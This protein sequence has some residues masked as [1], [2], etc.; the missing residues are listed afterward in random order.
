MDRG[1]RDM[2]RMKRIWAAW[3]AV[4]M[5]V[6]L[7]APAA[8]AATATD[9]SE[10]PHR[11]ELRSETAATC[12]K[13]GEKVYYCMICGS[14]RTETVKRLPHDYGSW[15]TVREATCAR[16]GERTRKCK[17][18][19]HEDTRSIDRLPHQWGEWTVLSEPTDH[20]S[21]QRTRTCSVCG[22]TQEEAIDPEGTL[23][24]GD[25]GEAVKAL[26]DLLV[27]YG[28]LGRGGAD[29]S[30]GRGT[31]GAVKQV[32]AAEGLEADGVAWPQ[33]QAVLGHRFGEWEVVSELS[34]F[35]MGLRQRVCARCGYVEREE[36]WPSPM[37]RRGDR[38]DGVRALQNALSDA[39]YS[40]G[41]ADGDFGRRTESAV[42][43]FEAA[44][45]VQADGI[46][47]PG[48][49]RLLGLRN[50]G[51][52][53]EETEEETPDF[54]MI[55]TPFTDQKVFHVGEEIEFRPV[56]YNNA[57]RE[58][59]DAV[60]R[61]YDGRGE[62]RQQ[63]DEGTLPA[64]DFD[65]L[66]DPYTFVEADIGTVTFKWEADAVDADGNK[67]TA[68]PQ[69]LTYTV[70]PAEG[71]QTPSQ[72]EHGASAP[73]LL[74]DPTA[75]RAE[76]LSVVK[77]VKGDEDQV[78]SQGDIVTFEI[79]VANLTAD[80]M[81]DARVY[82]YV[83]GAEKGLPVA[84]GLTIKRYDTA[85]LNFD[86]IVTA[87]DAA[88]GYV[89]DYAVAE[90]GGS[91]ARSN[92]V[93]ILVQPGTPDPED[94]PVT[95]TKAIANL[96]ERGYFLVGET[97]DFTLTLRNDGDGDITDIVIRDPLCTAEDNVVDTFDALAPGGEQTA[98]LTYEVTALDLLHP[99]INIGFA[100]FDDPQGFTCTVI[101][102]EVEVPTGTEP[103]RD[104]DPIGV[105]TGAEVHKAVA[106]ASHPGNGWYYT[107]GED[108]VYEITVLNCGE[109]VLDEVTVYDTLAGGSGEI[110]AIE[111]FM[112]GDSRTYLFTHTVSKSDVK[113]GKVINQ[114]WI[115]WEIEGVPY[116]A[117]SERV[118]SPTGG[119]RA[120]EPAATCCVP[121]LTGAGLNQRTYTLDYCGEHRAVAYALDRAVEAAQTDDERLAAWNAAA[122]RW[123]EALNAEYD[124]LLADATED[125][126]TLVVGEKAL[127]FAQ[128]ACLKDALALTRPELTVAERMANQLMR[129]T[130]E[131]CY[132]RHTAPE[133]RTDSLYNP[134]EALP[135]AEAPALCGVHTE[136]TAGGIAWTETLCATHSPAEAAALNLLEEAAT[137]EDRAEAWRSVAQ[138]WLTALNSA[139]NARWQAAAEQGREIIA[140]ERVAF[141]KWLAAQEDLLNLLYPGRPVTTGERVARL[142]RERVLELERE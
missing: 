133:N 106:A 94:D 112:P 53:E 108:I 139:A 22:A 140:A 71:E 87:E 86:Y 72:E 30:F 5:L 81:T 9:P 25:R 134:H 62:L 132:A 29:G 138:I 44:H 109:T 1:M 125:E 69:T 142:L 59:T 60:V 135:E 130:A 70:L 90:G 54:D 105:I 85:V 124:A 98:H 122:Q 102:N 95:L 32:Q 91:V 21:G 131:L 128:L 48:V 126:Q 93:R 57:D 4:L 43:G 49:L 65:P 38:G 100:T 13:K 23:R 113:H 11:W 127:F 47:W 107:R 97:V 118:I 80:D 111:N 123:T 26:Q 17:V 120:A 114:A 28:V 45:G 15:R 14:T 66:Y 74:V 34:D 101:S 61:A 77:A 7:C 141:D 56:L 99:L 137:P 63:Y 37:Y 36:E 115:E 83:N 73:A 79:V 68:E 96:P 55:V 84:E 10:C 82:D 75:D 51:E 27:C 33:T 78:Y 6:G 41:H 89:T 88:R 31:E 8:I 39:G 119:E 12:A 136:I 20:S 35:S 116:E 110:A 121:T 40:V 2:L 103:E 50:G 42:A 16:E 67:L 129:K 64:N 92:D 46:A 52:P 19:G 18:C 3:L 117:W 24:R 58:M 104:P 76:A